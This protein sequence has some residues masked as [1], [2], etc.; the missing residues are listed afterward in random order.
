LH[1]HYLRVLA[2]TRINKNA[3]NSRYIAF[4]SVFYL[5][6]FF[7]NDDLNYPAPVSFWTFVPALSTYLINL[8]RSVLPL[9]VHPNVIYAQMSVRLG[10]LLSCDQNHA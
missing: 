10:E 5:I 8:R 3:L 4:F 9:I 6:D 7:A 1:Q 2:N